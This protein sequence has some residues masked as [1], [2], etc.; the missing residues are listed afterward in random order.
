MEPYVAAVDTAR[1]QIIAI[2]ASVA[3]FVTIFELIRRGKLRVEYSLVWFAA[4][5]VFLYFSIWRGS[6]DALAHKM[7][8]A[9][10]PALL[11]LLMLFFGSVLLVHFSIVISRLTSENKRLA[12]ELAIVKYHQETGKGGP[13]APGA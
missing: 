11:I 8:I 1:A 6:M 2:V 5:L 10:A 3:L 4:S 7:G 12:Q 9:Y 13:A